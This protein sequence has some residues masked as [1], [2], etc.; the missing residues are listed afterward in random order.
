MIKE[1]TLP[2]NYSENPK[3]PNYQPMK[4]FSLALLFS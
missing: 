1:S 4:Q 2:L 3:N